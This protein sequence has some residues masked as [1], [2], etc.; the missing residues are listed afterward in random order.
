MEDVRNSF[1]CTI[2][3]LLNAMNDFVTVDYA[4]IDEFNIAFDSDPEGKMLK[5][6]HQT[7]DGLAEILLDDFLAAVNLPSGVPDEVAQVLLAIS[8]GKPMVSFA[9][10]EEYMAENPSGDTASDKGCNNHHSKK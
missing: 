5:A 6:L 4:I 3:N 9:E 1:L 7:A 10:V 8:G 2:A